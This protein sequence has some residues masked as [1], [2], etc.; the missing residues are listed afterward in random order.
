MDHQAQGPHSGEDPQAM[1]EQ[2]AQLSDDILT[3]V[4]NAT[5]CL[6]DGSDL[7][8]LAVLYQF[9]QFLE[10]CPDETINTMVPQI[11]KDA[12]KW[13]TRLQMSAAEAL[14]SAVSLKL[15]EQVAKRVAVAS[16]RI[17]QAVGS[18]DVFDAF[19]EVLSGV[20]PQ[21]SRDDVLALIVPATKE[22]AVSD[23]IE[24]RRL[25]ARI[26]GSLANQL[27]PEEIQEEFLAQILTLL[28]DSDPSVRAMM[29]QSLSEVSAVLPL[30]VIET[31][32]WP[33]LI[34]M[35]KED[36]DPRV[37]ASSLRALARSCEAHKANAATSAAYSK[38]L[39][40]I[41]LEECDHACKVASSDLRTIDDDTYLM[42]EIFAEVYGYFLVGM[43]NAI[44][45][46]DDW[47]TSLNAL[48]RMVT[49]N[50]PTVRQWCAFNLPGVV[51]TA[52]F[53]RPDRIKGVLNALS[54]DNDVETRGALALG[55]HEVVKV[56]ASSDVLRK[57]TCLAVSTLF[58]DENGRVRLNAIEHFAE[59][60]EYLAKDQ[61]PGEAS[62]HLE[63]VF[64]N[65][66]KISQDS[67]RTQ[68]VLCQ[69]LGKLAHLCTSEILC[70]NVAPVL[71]QM[72]REST[73]LVRKSGMIALAH[74]LRY[75]PDAKKRDHILKHFRSQW[76]TGKV[77]WTRLAYIE[78]CYEAADVFSRKLYVQLFTSELFTMVSDP[79]PNVRLRLA[80]VFRKTIAAI[81]DLSDFK[82]ALSTLMQDKDPQVL[83]EAKEIKKMCDEF[84][85]S[86][87]QELEEDKKKEAAENAFFVMKKKPPKPDPAAAAAPA[88]APSSLKSTPASGSQPAPVV[89]PKPNP[90]PPAPAPQPKPNPASNPPAPKPNPQGQT[91]VPIPAPK[92]PGPP[93]GPPRPFNPPPQPAATAPEKKQ[94]CCTIS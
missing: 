78:A 91:Q 56:L 73:Y 49:C 40:P 75:I 82:V 26:I 63:R 24:S 7:E 50:G 87:P 66:E 10:H 51:L 30:S 70:N 86:S 27:H 68:E 92:P 67:W 17:I 12:I 61:P 6:M 52:A 20:L 59:D 33:R 19:G 13:D 38:L 18:G 37:R 90:Q 88:A 39:L 5:L 41:F 76:A 80:A 2:V 64:S 53:R 84:K 48:R 23:Q 71:F 79:V 58:N 31:Q 47:T 8:K 25:A 83:M 43:E 94:G 44:R 72:A 89:A 22:R 93:P 34:G 69:Q 46:D 14:Y 57:E 3:S 21:I 36:K 15:P 29:G 4:A 16:L 62:V 54:T 60:M 55:I 35:L 65:L 9:R 1:M 45:S 74:V 32:I 81:K 28:K 11:C 42:V 85:G 77:H